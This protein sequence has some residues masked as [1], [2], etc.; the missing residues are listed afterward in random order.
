ML[1]FKT[2]GDINY[3][4][5]FYKECQELRITPAIAMEALA[6]ARSVASIERQRE[7]SAQELKDIQSTI[8]YAKEIRIQL[9][10]RERESKVRERTAQDGTT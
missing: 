3:Y 7:T 5:D 8:Q 1:N 4:L 6:M 2:E 9:A 10:K